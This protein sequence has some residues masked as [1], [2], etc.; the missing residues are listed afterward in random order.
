MRPNLLTLLGIITFLFSAALPAARGGQVVIIDPGHGGKDPGCHRCGI[1]EKNLTLSLA[2]RTAEELRAKGHKVVMT[3]TSD[4]YVS[5]DQRAAIANKYPGALMISL[6]CNADLNKGARGVETYY[7]GTAG[8]S[9]ASSLHREVSS[10][11]KSPNRG[12]KKRSL[13]VL[14][15]TEGPAALV[16]YGFLSNASERARI[17]T[18]EYQ[19]KIARAIGR[20]LGSYLAANGKSGKGSLLASARR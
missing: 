2:K 6:H 20:G 11:A 4:R 5:L 9:L 13:A 7:A 17:S 1:F 10:T 16:E 8:R 15:K 18:G 14:R 3:R 12:I 19:S